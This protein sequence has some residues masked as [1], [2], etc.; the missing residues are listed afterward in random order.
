MKV[1]LDHVVHIAENINTFWFKPDH[2]PRYT[3]GQFIELTLPHPNAD[4]RGQKRWFTLSSSPS[5]ELVSITTKFASQNG[6]S[7]KRTLANLKPGD[8]VHMSETMGDFVLPKDKTAKLIFV[9][10]G[11][12][13]TPIRSMVKWM[14]DTHEAR[15]VHVLYAANS[16]GD[17]AFL[18]IFEASKVNLIRTVKDAPKGW[19]GEIGRLS[20][21]R[22][23]NLIGDPH[24]NT[25]VYLS[26]PEPMVE[27]L[28]DDLKKAGF[29]KKRLVTDYFPGYTEV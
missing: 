1:V 16:P 8:Q 18:D 29:N 13:V 10:G 11:I 28:V 15:D 23:M 27:Q 25:Y 7:F 24:G 2:T 22:I 20:A 4:N 14:T 17:F 21:E 5:E 3:A 19:D 26:G 6:S 9:A 12:G